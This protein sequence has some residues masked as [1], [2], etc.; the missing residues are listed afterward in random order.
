MFLEIII[1]IF[2][3]YIF[4]FRSIKGKP[5]YNNTVQIIS[6]KDLHRI[7]VIFLL[8]LDVASLTHCTVL[9]ENIYTADAHRKGARR[10]AYPYEK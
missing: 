6:R 8:V 9:T 4:S 7:D 5:F 10:G 1:S 2:F 3:N